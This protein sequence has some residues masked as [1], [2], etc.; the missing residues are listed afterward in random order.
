MNQ[1]VKNC[2]NCKK[3]FTIEPDDFAFYQKI[4]VPPPTFCPECRFARRALFR[5]ER[6]IFKGTNALTGKSLMTFYPPELKFSIYEDRDWWSQEHWDP[7]SYG[8]DVDLDRPFLSQIFE[9]FSKTPKMATFAINMINSEYA[10]NADDL[11]NCYL[12]FNSNHTEDSAYGNGVDFSK[13]CYDNSHIK[14]SER[15]YGSFWVTNCYETIFSAQCIDCIAVWCSKNCRDL[16]NCFGCVNLR[17]KQYC[18]WNEQYTREEYES[19]LHAMRLDT[20]TGLQEAREKTQE[21]WLRYPHKNIQGIKNINVS[22]EYISHSKNVQKSYLV[23]ESENLKY[24]QYAQVPSS[25]DCMDGSLI[26]SGSE[27]F[28]EVAICGWGSSNLKFCWDCWDGG[29]ELE[30]SI[31][32]GRSAVNCFGCVGILKQQYCILNKQYTK[33][34]YIALRE[35]IIE[36]MNAIPYVDKGGRVYKYGEFFP[37]EFSPFAYQDT[38]VPEHFLMG[39]EAV[40]KFGARWRAAP[41]AEYQVTMSANQIPNAIQDVGKE[42]VKELIECASCKRAYRIIETELQFFKQLN[43]PLP[44]MCVDCRHNAR[45][46]WRNRAKLYSRCC[47]CAGEKSENAVYQNTASHSHG[48]APCPSTFETSYSPEQSEIVYCEQCYN[49]EVA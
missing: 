11:K 15:C 22:G 17:S 48:S 36:H 19:R 7:L 6:K 16:N 31:S 8:K 25:R 2:Q 1:E 39:E 40:E 5:N 30:Y 49:V 10:G 20:W 44:R 3:D 27:L 43:I 47:H 28:Y 46:A 23:R 29:R 45:I 32:C 21:F 12:L 26:G 24:V 4:N 9:I 13:N 34:E 38:I 18:I 42:I 41:R 14:K 33:N 35:K 37:P